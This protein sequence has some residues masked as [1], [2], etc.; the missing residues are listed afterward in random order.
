MTQM[1]LPFRNEKAFDFCRRLADLPQA[2]EY[3]F[4]IGPTDEAA[5]LDLLLTC[6]AFR[7]LQ[8][9]YPD[10]A[11][12]FL[13]AADVDEDAPEAE[14]DT[15][16][17]P[18]PINVEQWMRDAASAGNFTDRVDVIEENCQTYARMLAPQSPE[19][20]RLFQYMLREAIRN[21]PEHGETNRLWI[22]GRIWPDRPGRP[23]ELAVL[24]EG[25]GIHQS[26]ARNSRHREFLSSNLEALEWAL[27]P[28]VSAAFDPAR[29][30]RS[31]DPYANSGYGLYM[32]QQ[33]CRMTGGSMTLVSCEDALHLLPDDAKAEKA[34]LHG[35]ALAM[36]IHT[37]KV[38]SCQ[39]LIDRARRQGEKEA[40]TIRNAFRTA[41]VPS[42]GLLKEDQ[43]P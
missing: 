2:D 41:S 16:L 21:A 28:G 7:Q 35:T 12:R 36:R 38:H 10:A 30:N 40:R 27:K 42:R 26:L 5:P 29:G 34:C 37:D 4:C 32:I 14:D 8:S 25:I 13:P 22:C 23:A 6:A 18:L 11:C 43:D 17:P 39:E 15:L 31:S 19:L 1:I 9:V 20:R 24:D 33:I 3:V